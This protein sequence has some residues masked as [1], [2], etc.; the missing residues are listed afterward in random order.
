[1]LPHAAPAADAAVRLLTFELA[2]QRYALK[3]TDVIEIQRA[4]AIARLPR[5]PA[6]VE[7]AINVRGRLVAVL[8]VRSRFGLPPDP[9]AP[10]NHFILAQLTRATAHGVRTVAIRVD[11]ALDLVIVNRDRIDDGRSAIPGVEFVAG[12]AKLDDALIV[13]H[14]LDA[15]LSIDEAKDLERALSQREAD[16]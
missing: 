12:L 11:R 1:M 6:I 15:F 7:G 3:A 13:I 10:S 14:D 16:G 8:D 9:L 2:G 4:V 5:C